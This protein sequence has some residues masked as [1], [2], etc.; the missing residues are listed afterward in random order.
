M[1]SIVVTKGWVKEWESDTRFTV[2]FDAESEEDRSALL[3]MMKDRVRL[4]VTIE[5]SDTAQ[6]PDSPNI[7]KSCGKETDGRI[8]INGKGICR[9]CFDKFHL[10]E[11]I[12]FSYDEL[13]E[14]DA[15]QVD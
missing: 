3:D 12:G 11:R 8:A 15:N 13:F 9:D 5:K 10:D 2:E 7:C 6:I 4:K 1:K 14:K